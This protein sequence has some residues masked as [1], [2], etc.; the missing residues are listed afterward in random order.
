MKITHLI[1]V[2]VIAVAIAII[3]TSAGDASQYVS[4]DTAAQLAQNGDKAKVH[5]VGELTR[6]A[7][8]EIAGIEYDPFK[9]PNF[10]AFQLIDEAGKTRRVVTY[11]PPPSLQDFKRSEKVVIVG[12]WKEEQFIAD[13]ILLKCPSKYE[14]NQL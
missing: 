9:N 2:A 8:G 10:M 1:G 7:Q 3:V 13:D 5:V 14:E 11:N 4:F 6:D 12:S